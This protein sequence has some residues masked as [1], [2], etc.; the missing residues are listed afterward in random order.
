M[1]KSTNLCLNYMFILIQAV[2]LSFCPFWDL[3]VQIQM[4]NY[5][6]PLVERYSYGKG[7]W[8][9][10]HSALTFWMMFF[11]VAT[12][13]INSSSSICGNKSFAGEKKNEYWWLQNID[14]S[15]ESDRNTRT[16]I[17]D[18]FRPAIMHYYFSASDVLSREIFL[19]NL[20]ARDAYW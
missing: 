4:K 17:I 20:Y 19:C 5:I 11:S 9:R 12:S 14:F 15:S 1:I 7:L 13:K 6:I 16:N 18:A 3:F 8:H 2:N 10:F